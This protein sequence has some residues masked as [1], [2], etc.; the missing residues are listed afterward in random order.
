MAADQVSGPL[1]GVRVLELGQLIAGPWCATLLGHYGAQVIKVEPPTGD[2]IRTW[3]TLHG[4]TSVWWASIARNKRLISLDLRTDA[5][6]DVIRRL[7][8]TVDVVVENFR[9][10]RL[11]DWGLGPDV[12]HALN[13]RLVL[14]R[15]SGYGQTG[16]YRER[17]GYASVAEAVGGLRHLTGPPGGPTQ[18]AN[19]S[20]GDTVAGLTAAFGVLLGLL[21]RDRSGQG[22]VVDVALVEAVLGLLEGVLPQASVGV[23]RQASGGTI[24]GVVPSGAFP[25]VDGQVVLGANGA[26]VFRRLC[27]AM[28]RP[29]LADDPRFVDNP[30]RVANQP[31]LDRA[32]AAWTGRHT[33]DQVVAALTA[34]RVPAGP[35]QDGAAL[36]QDPQLA[37]RGMLERV[38]V[39]GQPL[40]IPGVSPKLTHAPGRTR[41]PGRGLG[42]DTDAVLSELGLS[43][44]EI[45]SL[46]DQGVAR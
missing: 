14:C 6:R 16:P 27:Q 23:V 43:A 4:D 7:I 34:A 19:L 21:Q 30:A 13:P 41:W 45:Q 2:P 26:G 22:E 44:A 31:L 5:G 42:H 11:E 8:P 3:R 32:I 24:T 17:P 39:G 29:E 1:E 12:L 46:R 35:I 10:G 36:L 15:V 18:R 38:T 20:I 33:V 40:V 9:P 25:C 28:G 37:S